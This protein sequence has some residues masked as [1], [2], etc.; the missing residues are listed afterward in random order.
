MSP[1]MN[2]L[3][4]IADNGYPSD[5]FFARVRARRAALP[6][7]RGG[8]VRKEAQPEPAAEVDKDRRLLQNELRWCFRQMNGALR[9]IFRTVFL[10]MELKTIVLC[11][12]YHAALKPDRIEAVLVDSLL[13]REIRASLTDGTETEN[14]ISQIAACFGPGFLTPAWKNETTPRNM[15]KRFE[16]ELFASFMQWTAETRLRPEITFFFR[17][18]I[19]CRN[20]VLAAK[21]RRWAIKEPCRL[22]QGGLIGDNKVLGTTDLDTGTAAAGVFAGSWA[23]GLSY[24]GYPQLERALF[25]RVGAILTRRSRSGDGIDLTLDYLWQRSL[26]ARNDSLVRQAEAGMLPPELLNG[27]FIQ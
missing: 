17:L 8:R 2:V 7:D 9:E 18:L 5:Y 22:L 12:R 25:Q 6:R 11:L 21:H 19:D 20:L 13:A 24:D 14:A 3:S 4:P 23:D 10:F 26:A 1:P 15:I 16:S 27:E